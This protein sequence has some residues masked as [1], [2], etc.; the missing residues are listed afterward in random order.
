MRFE[1]NYVSSQTHAVSVEKQVLPS[2]FQLGKKKGK[3]KSG[4]Q[5]IL[6]SSKRTRTATYLGSQGTPGQ[7][8]RHNGDQ[9]IFI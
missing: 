6:Q 7:R 1:T 9:D 3:R 4:L 8:R 5:K 2:V